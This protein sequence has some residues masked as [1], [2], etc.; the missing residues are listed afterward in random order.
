MGNNESSQARSEIDIFQQYSL[1]GVE[2]N[3]KFGDVSV[4]KDKSSGEIVWIK[5]IILDDKK[6]ETALDSYIVS[7]AWKN[8]SFITSQVYKISPKESFLCSAQ[9]SGVRRLAVIMHHYERDLQG[10]IIQRASE[11]EKDFFPEPEIWY[12]IESI[13]GLEALVLKQN[14]F[15]GDIRTSTI[16][17]T[18]DGQ[19]KYTD[20]NLLDQ[21]GSA[22][23]RTVLGET[24]SNLP[25][26]HLQAWQ[27]GQREIKSNQE[28]ADTFAL[29]IVILALAT[30]QEDNWYYDWQQ[31]DLQWA[32]IKDSLSEVQMRYSPL[33]YQLA[34]GCLKER[35]SERIRIQDVLRFIEQRKNSDY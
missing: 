18:D 19:T 3:P 8:S 32:R 13:M 2:E 20:P 14:R 21:Q 7:E 11:F 25:P 24:R 31:K 28:V 9:C 4:Y 12:I 34:L 16:F 5:D 15:H 17:I 33:L 22:F 23:I 6:T 10:E 27:A 29:G 26:E 35:M 1:L 30:L